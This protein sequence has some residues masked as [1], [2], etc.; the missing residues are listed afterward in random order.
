MKRPQEKPRDKPHFCHDENLE[1]ARLVKECNQGAI[2][3]SAI[4]LMRV[5]GA[6]DPQIIREC[7]KQDIHIIT[8]NTDHF[9]NPPENIKIG[10]ICIGK[11]LDKEFIKKVNSLFSKHRKHAFYYQKTFLIDDHITMFSRLKKTHTILQ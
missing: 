1:F 5:A 11:K 10:I 3:I 7:N 4:K 9:R 6:K 8:K 2:F